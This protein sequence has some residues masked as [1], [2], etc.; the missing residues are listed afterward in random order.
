MWQESTFDLEYSGSYEGK[1]QRMALIHG[2]VS[3]DQ[4]FYEAYWTRN[5]SGGEGSQGLRPRLVISL[6]RASQMI[7]L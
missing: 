2:V 7:V 3:P 5:E 1:N 4:V 6:S